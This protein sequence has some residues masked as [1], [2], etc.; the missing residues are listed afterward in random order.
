MPQ[1]ISP[2]DL[3]NAGSSPFEGASQLAGIAVAAGALYVARLGAVI[4]AFIVGSAAASV[5]IRKRRMNAPSASLRSPSPANRCPRTTAIVLTNLIGLEGRKF[6]CPHSFGE[7]LVNLGT[8]YDDPVAYRDDFYPAAGTL[9]TRTDTRVADSQD[10][11]R[12]RPGLRRDLE[13][14]VRRDVPAGRR[15]QAL[16]SVQPRAE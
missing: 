1:G 10:H 11:V 2:T 15:R 13:P 12:A 5:L 16:G 7:I 14:G 8:A 4:P 9:D 3:V 6:T